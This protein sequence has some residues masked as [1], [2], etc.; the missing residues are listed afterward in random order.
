MLGGMNVHH[1]IPDAP[2]EEEDFFDMANLRPKSTGLPMTVWVS[3]KGHARHDA[4]VKVCRTP[5]DR[6]DVDDLAVVGIRPQPTL[7]E[8]P[9]D[10]QS[11]RLVEQW[12]VL[13]A[14]T[15]IGYWD[16]EIDTADLIQG[17]QRL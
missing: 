9:L 6:M 12:I 2:V 1:P 3:H 5:G 13:N 14:E 7:I 11:L 4:R 15:L 17:L 10:T 8:G 16:G